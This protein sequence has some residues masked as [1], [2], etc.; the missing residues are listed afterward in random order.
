VLMVDEFEGE[1]AGLLLVEAEFESDD[2][3]AT[4]VPPPF[5]AREITGDARFTGA[6]LAR[7]GRPSTD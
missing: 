2:R 6:A 7:D 3:M 1:L 4:F 5:A